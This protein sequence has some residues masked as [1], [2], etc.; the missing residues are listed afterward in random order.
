LVG[1]VAGAVLF[2]AP[3]LNLSVC[4]SFKCAMT[5]WSSFVTEATHTPM[6]RQF[7]WLPPRSPGGCLVHKNGR[8]K[9][10]SGLTPVATCT[11]DYRSEAHRRGIVAC[12]TSWDQHDRDHFYSMN[13]SA[14][15]LHLHVVREPLE[16]LVSGFI[17]RCVHRHLCARIRLDGTL[18]PQLSRSE[19]A[20]QREEERSA[21]WTQT[22]ES[23]ASWLDVLEKSQQHHPSC[24]T[25][26]D[27]FR[28]QGCD[29][30]D[31][32]HPRWPIVFANEAPASVAQV[33]AGQHH[34]STL[35]LH[36]QVMAVCHRQGFDHTRL[37]LC[38]S[39]FPPQSNSAH[40][41]TKEVLNVDAVRSQPEL[42]AKVHRLYSGDFAM[43]KR[44][45][46]AASSVLL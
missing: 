33:A 25:T 3:T 7:P 38:R 18:L 35:N 26:D 13:T 41:T 46:Y 15:M 30:G 37:Q 39:L 10:N 22:L 2:A 44:Y 45:Y 43:Y 8:I 12:T 28:A 16:R 1:C 4:V 14:S 6:D 21:N 11:C 23:F 40:R 34:H 5:Q 20:R 17:N 27:H 29:C 9:T 24:V 36:E 19:Q 32:T 42:L 31:S